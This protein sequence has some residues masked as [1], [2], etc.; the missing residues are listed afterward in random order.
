ME[1]QRH[2][3]IDAKK[4]KW[5]M[6]GAI[7]PLN[8]ARKVAYIPFMV[9][10]GSIRKW[11]G[12]STHTRLSGATPQP[13]QIGPSTPQPNKIIQAQHLNLMKSTNQIAQISTYIV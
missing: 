1:H 8:D 3:A 10:E 2:I 5:C 6:E 9:H 4:Y 13:Y 7:D 12:P 11:T